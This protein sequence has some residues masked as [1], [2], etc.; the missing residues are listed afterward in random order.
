MNLMDTKPE[1]I[2]PKRIF[3]ICDGCEIATDKVIYVSASAGELA[4]I[5]SLALDRL[6]GL[7][8]DERLDGV[9]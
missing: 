2:S 3:E 6:A 9:R 5:F 7:A 1:P 8:M 4:Q